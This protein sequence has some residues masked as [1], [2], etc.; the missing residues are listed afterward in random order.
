VAACPECGA[1]LPG[2]ETCRDRFTSAQLLEGEQPGR[3]TVH[4]LSVPCFML[5]HHGYTLRGWLAARELVREFLE[6][7]LTAAQAARRVQRGARGADRSWSCTRGARPPG[8]ESVH[9]TRTIAEVRLE[10]A[11]VYGADVRAWA[12]AIVR[13]TEAIARELA[14]P[15]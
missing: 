11:D 12:Q 2:E 4:H 14:P 6:D 9:W 5:Q 7:G 3:Y 8:I 15:A 1:R 13:D 10:D